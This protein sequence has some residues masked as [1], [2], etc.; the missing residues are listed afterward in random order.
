MPDTHT[1]SSTEQDL[2]EQG[3]EWW[4]KVAQ[5][6]AKNPGSKELVPTTFQAQS[7][8]IDRDQRA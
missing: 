8:L 1:W 2:V 7:C 5:A 4:P 6:E 3:V